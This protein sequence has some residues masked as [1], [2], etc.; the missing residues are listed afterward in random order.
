LFA[1]RGVNT[2]SQVL[3]VATGQLQKLGPEQRRNALD[4]AKR[5]AEPG[6]RAVITD[7]LLS[8]GLL[9]RLGA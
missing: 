9:A 1:Q 5:L 3:V 4:Q 6:A 2:I 8:A 7:Y